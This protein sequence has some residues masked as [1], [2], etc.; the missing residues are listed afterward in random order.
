LTLIVPIYFPNNTRTDDSFGLTIKNPTATRTDSKIPI[1]NHGV[2]KVIIPAIELPR[3]KKN[4]RSIQYPDLGLKF[5]SI[6]I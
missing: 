1:I 4:T 6:T 3:I 2:S 5:F